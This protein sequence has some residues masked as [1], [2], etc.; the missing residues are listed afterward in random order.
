VGIYPAGTIVELSSGEIAVV[1]SEYRTRRLKP[2]VMILLDANKNKLREPRMFD[3]MEDA[4]DESTQQLNIVQSL[5][6]EAY[7]I[8]LTQ[9]QI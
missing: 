7:D 8:D 1:V 6:P 9:L 2:K 5:E 4:G 3:M